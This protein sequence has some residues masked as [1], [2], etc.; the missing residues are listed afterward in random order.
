MIFA[1][2][3]KKARNKTERKKGTNQKQERHGGITECTNEE[4]KTTRKGKIIKKERKKNKKKE[5]K[6][7]MGGTRI[8]ALSKCY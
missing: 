3:G 1:L 4:R 8:K 2:V 7:T 5:R 6:K